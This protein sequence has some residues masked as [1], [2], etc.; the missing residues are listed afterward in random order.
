MILYTKPSYVIINQK[1][2]Q[3]PIW[4]Y[5]I[6]NDMIIHHPWPSLISSKKTHASCHHP[7]S[8]RKRDGNWALKSWSAA[9]QVLI[10]PGQEAA[11]NWVFPKIGV[12]QNGW[13]IMENQWLLGTTI[14]GTP[15]LGMIRTTLPATNFLHLKNGLEDDCF[16]LGW[17]NIAGANC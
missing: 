9:H 7:P 1:H 17:L 2:D 8:P 13:F 3:I 11:T 15:Q 16:L 10:F 5:P 14:L 4:S 12:P 6:T